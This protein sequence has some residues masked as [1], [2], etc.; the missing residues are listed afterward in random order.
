M[1]VTQESE[2]R[3]RNTCGFFRVGPDFLLSFEDESFKY[4]P[5]L[6]VLMVH[7]TMPTLETPIFSPLIFPFDFLL[8]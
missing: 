5:I 1:C 7:Q 4:C 2:S 6:L 8:M 3:G